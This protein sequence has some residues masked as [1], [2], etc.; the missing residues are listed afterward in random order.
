MPT[1]WRASW[2]RRRSTRTG[3]T[4]PSARASRSAAADASYACCTFRGSV[5]ALDIA[6]GRVVWKTY[7]LSEEPRPIA[8][9]AGER[10]D[11]GR[12]AS[13]STAPRPS[14]R[15]GVSLYVATGDSFNPALQPHGRCG[16]R[17]RSCRRPGALVEAAVAGRSEGT[18]AARE[19]TCLA[20]PAHPGERQAGHPRRPEIRRCVWSRSGSG[21]RG[22]CGRSSGAGNE[23]RAESN[24][25]PAAD[26]R[27]VYVALSGLRAEP[28]NPTGGLAALD[29]RTGAKR[30]QPRAARLACSWR[31][32]TCAH[33]QAQAVTVIPGAAF[34][35]SMDGHLRAYSTIDGK[36]M[37]D[38]DTAKDFPT[39]NG[40]KAERRLA[41]SGRRDHRQ[42]RRVR[43]F[44]Q[45][46]RATRAMCCSHF[47]S[48]ANR[49][50]NLMPLLK[51]IFRG[52]PCVLLALSPRPCLRADAVRAAPAPA[53]ENSVVKV[54]STMRHPDPFKP[55]T[56]QAP[57]EVSGSGV[58]IE[59]KRI[60]TNAHVVLYATQVQVQANA[61]GDKVSATVVAVAP[62]IDLAVLQLDDASVLRHP[63]AARARE[64]AAADQGRGAGLR[65]S[66][67]RHV[68]LDH[69]G[70]RV[71]HRVR[72]R[73]TI[74]VSGLRI[75]VDAAIN[76]GNSGGPAIAGDKMI[77]LAFSKL[78][79]AIRRTS[80]TSFRTR[81]SICSS[82]T[83]PTA[84][85]TASPRCTTICRRSRI[86]RCA[87]T[88]SSTNPSRAWSSIGPTRTTPPIR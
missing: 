16:R 87:S 51:R 65:L 50:A 36:I 76:P 47:Q 74:P 77:G 67:R 88:S 61:A 57:T 22:I 34:S 64:R 1:R 29:M 45:R 71:A 41:G 44:G 9:G 83:S 5:A 23:T 31:R 13:R 38:Y 40:V 43:Q 79:A 56:K 6:T 28:A 27:S 3:C 58:V 4:S 53:I 62:G 19:F 2:A 32:P 42:R 78:W 55:W 33:G 68:A 72:R 69:Q 37:W 11:S 17:A 14:T 26:H 73:T 30:W 52:M 21:R 75:Q 60:L 15:R 8:T 49:T 84:I 82:R 66:D 86:P 7:L 70:H 12:R 85:T 25:A 35:G 81:R 80:A 63:S 54:F 46:T 39:V 10:S 48:T 24:G 20:D 59:G 18:G